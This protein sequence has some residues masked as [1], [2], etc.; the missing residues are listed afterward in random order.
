[1]VASVASQA[2]DNDGNTIDTWVDALSQQL[3]TLRTSVMRV[4]DVVKLFNE[5]QYAEEALEADALADELARRLNGVFAAKER[6]VKSLAAAVESAWTGAK[7]GEGSTCQYQDASKQ[8]IGLTPNPLYFDAVSHEFSAVKLAPDA[9]VDTRDICVTEALDAVFKANDPDRNLPWQY[10]GINKGYHR[11]YPASMRTSAYDAR[12]RPWYTGAS[13]GPKDVVL[14]LDISGSMAEYDRI[15]LMKDAAKTVLASLTI[16]DYVNVVVFSSGAQTFRCASDTLLP[17]DAGT[18]AYMQ[19]EIDGLRA[20]GST[21]FYKAFDVAFQTLERTKRA[22]G[23]S[24]CDSNRVILFLTDGKPTNTEDH[25]ALIAE[26]NRDA[27][28]AIFTYAL[29]ANAAVQKDIACDNKGAYTFIEDGGNL[30]TKMQSYYQVFGATANANIFWTAP[31]LDA[32]GLGMMVTAALP[33]YET[34]NEFPSLIGVVGHDILLS[35]FTELVSTFASGRSYAFLVDRAGNAISHPRMSSNSNPNEA[36]IYQDISVLENNNATDFFTSVRAPLLSGQPG[37][38]R[39]V[40]TRV[41]TRG[42]SGDGVTFERVA[43]TYVWRPVGPFV[44][45]YVLA[46][47]DVLALTPVDTAAPL[48]VS[49]Y[50]NLVRYAANAKPTTVSS[51]GGKYPGQT[52]LPN[53]TTFYLAP[54]AYNNS[55]SR[56]RLTPETET[57]DD[58]AVLHAAIND[59]DKSDEVAGLRVGIKATVRRLSALDAIWVGTETRAPAMGWIYLGTETG[60]HRRYPGGLQGSRQYDPTARPWYLRAKALPNS[61]VVSAPYTDASGLGRV[62]TLANSI[63]RRIGDRGVGGVI[64]LDF[65]YAA[66]EALVHSNA[67]ACFQNT[68]SSCFAIEGSGLLVTSDVARHQV[69][70]APDSVFLGAVEPGVAQALLAANF[71]Q[72]QAYTDFQQQRQCTSYRTNIDALDNVRSLKIST[73]G[74]GEIRVRPVTVRGAVTNLFLVQLV[75]FRQSSIG[76]RPLTRGCVPLAKPSPCAPMQL[77]AL[78]RVKPTCPQTMI[79]PE[80]L[81][82]VRSLDPDGGS[83]AGLSTVEIAV[84]VVCVILGFC[85]IVGLIVWLLKRRA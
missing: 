9:N 35:D 34:L 54:R 32:S 48:N 19:R 28:V 25:M 51:A 44:A 77:S 56:L 30:R 83:C 6:I 81:E 23:G 59:A 65:Q 2:V 29:G 53:A 1:M 80:F 68:R 57:A 69:R 26:K 49:F 52:L 38:H 73:C 17:A 15:S 42:D 24:G 14:V 5:T 10:V 45:C 55:A 78:P 74:V 22:G 61:L 8:L 84:T 85:C 70:T 47:D 12:S 62:I 21:D 7:G 4:D 46:E 41:L 71:L 37:K 66:F 72:E 79:T 31:Y 39:L 64:G 13:S 60:V 75:D 76:C 40:V 27:N 43:V 36:P 82:H 20:T 63:P 58:V 16:N 33:A 18:I 50:D 11:Q 3:A 67:S